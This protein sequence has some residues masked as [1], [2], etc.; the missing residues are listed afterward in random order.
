VLKW[1]LLVGLVAVLYFWLKRPKIVSHVFTPKPLIPE[2]LKIVPCA[3]CGVH[4]PAQ[5]C[6]EYEQRHYCCPDHRNALDPAGWYGQAQWRPSPNHDA[7]PNETVPDLVLMHHIS[8]PPGQF[9]NNYISDFFQ[10]KLDFTAHA[11]F[12]EISGQQVSSHF[13]ID[14]NGLINQFVST[15]KRAW[16]AG[17]SNFCGREQCNDFA[18]GI[19]LEGDG[20]TSFTDVQYVA[21]E[22]LL[23]VLAKTYTNLSFAG[24]SDVSPQR[25]TDPGIHFDWRRLQRENNLSQKK[26]PYGLEPRA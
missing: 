9:G 13:L 3:Y 12:A 25:K 8:L 26:L 5:D 20:Q 7:R 21:L 15:Q 18:I 1:V 16:H 22:Q 11:Y 2:P 19:E 24:H 4:L 6:I 14:R 17:V 23:K 10:N